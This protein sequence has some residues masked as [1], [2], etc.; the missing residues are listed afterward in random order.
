MPPKTVP[1][2][3]RRAVR[4]P[5]TLP[6]KLILGPS[7]AVRCTI[8]NLSASGAKVLLPPCGVAPARKVK[9][10]FTTDYTE[11]D[12]NVVWVV[13]PYAGLKFTSTF[14]RLPKPSFNEEQREWAGVPRAFGKPRVR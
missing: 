12:A 13:S 10:Q 5:I 7:E 14:R 9:L 11:V 1:V 6:A 4:K 8:V 2:E 3:R